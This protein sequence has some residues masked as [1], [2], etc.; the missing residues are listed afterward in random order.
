MFENL[1]I[2]DN[3]QDILKF[4]PDLKLN[5]QRNLNDLRVDHRTINFPRIIPI[6]QVNS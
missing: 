5:N 2:S 6:P 4:K 1:E 3:I